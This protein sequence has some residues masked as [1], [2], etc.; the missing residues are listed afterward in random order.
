MRVGDDLD[1]D[2]AIAMSREAMEELGV[3]EGDD[4]E[5]YGAWMQRA[6]TV[7]FNEKDITV[8][9]MHRKLREAL[10]CAVG[11]TVGIRKARTK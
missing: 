4:V 9:R 11:Q 3:R 6:K 8:V 10:P 7:L 1:Q 2:G 5:I